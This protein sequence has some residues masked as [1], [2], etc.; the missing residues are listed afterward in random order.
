MKSVINV[1][2]NTFSCI[3]Q[4]LTKWLKRIHQIREISWEIKFL[5]TNYNKLLKNEYFYV[6]FD[7]ADAKRFSFIHESLLFSKHQ[8]TY[9]DL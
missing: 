3:P 2:F 8:I 4:Y 7:C 1:E 5:V 9:F 6:P